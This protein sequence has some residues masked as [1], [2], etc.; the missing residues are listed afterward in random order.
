MWKGRLQF[1]QYIPAKQV[2]F[3]VKI[4]NL[5]ESSSAYL[6]NSKIYLG[7]G[8]DKIPDGV[9]ESIG[10]SGSVVTEMM[11]SLL[12]KGYHVYLDNWYPSISLF[13]YLREE[14][15]GACGTS[16]KNRAKELP[17]HFHEKD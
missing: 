12:G 2:R 7:K 14:E 15:T 11:A 10:K 17:S 3:G 8:S 9:P 4:Y 5:C 1:R 13:R 6:W 16:R